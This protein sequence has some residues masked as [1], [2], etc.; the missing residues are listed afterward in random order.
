MEEK[1]SAPIAETVC[2]SEIRDA[3]KVPS[4]LYRG[5]IVYFCTGAYVRP[6]QGDPDR[7]ISGEIEHPEH[8][9]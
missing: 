5:G 6:F 3:E 7:F 2:G 9:E 1:W 8:D 4:S